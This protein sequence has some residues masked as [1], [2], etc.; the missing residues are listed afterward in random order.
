[1]REASESEVSMYLAASGSIQG[2]EVR[3]HKGHRGDAADGSP[4]VKDS[5]TC[6]SPQPI[7]IARISELVNLTSI[8]RHGFHVD[9][10]TAKLCEGR[11]LL[12]LTR[13]S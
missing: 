4:V 9:R 5:F 7:R 13:P 8:R 2:S 12:A 6:G 1:M 3:S 11:T 10:K